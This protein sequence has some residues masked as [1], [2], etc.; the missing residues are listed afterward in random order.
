MLSIK[1]RA[2]HHIENLVEKKLLLD[3]NVE[4]KGKTLYIKN[5]SKSEIHINIKQ[6][7]KIIIESC[8]ESKLTLNVN[9]IAQLECIS[10]KD[11]H[12]EIDN[13]ENKFKNFLMSIDK[14]K[15][16][17]FG[18]TPYHDLDEKDLNKKMKYPEFQIISAN[19]CDKNF[20][21]MNQEKHEIKQAEDSLQFKSMILG[22][23]LRTDGLIRENGYLTTK[24][25]QEIFDKKQKLFDQKIEEMIKT[26]VIIGYFNF[27]D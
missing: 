22:N 10:L 20:I 4:L 15:N 18:F 26:M 2:I 14:A 21:I 16:C 24:V 19:D 8:H 3:D 25:E 5:C 23:K 17:N 6:I 1:P 12:V 9:I 7:T 27:L 11:C 13:S